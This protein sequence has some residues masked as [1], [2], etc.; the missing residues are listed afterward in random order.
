[1]EKIRY[2]QVK[3]VKIFV[4]VTYPPSPIINDFMLMKLKII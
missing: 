4:Y 2:T 1:M 3:L